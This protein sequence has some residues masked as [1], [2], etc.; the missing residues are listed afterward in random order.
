MEEQLR[1]A[2]EKMR[3]ESTEKITPKYY[4]IITDFVYFAI[5]IKTDIFVC[6]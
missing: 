4:S 6:Q 1:Q 2:E 5:V 3:L